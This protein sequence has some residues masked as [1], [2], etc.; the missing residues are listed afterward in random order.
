MDTAQ[1]SWNS[2]TLFAYLSIGLI[3]ATYL[4]KQ[5]PF[6]QKLLIPNAIIAGVIVLILSQKV[7]N[8]INIPAGS[9]NTLVYHLLTGV[10][11]TL[12]LQQRKRENY[13][14]VIITTTVITISNAV[15]GLVGIAFTL[16]GSLVLFQDLHPAFS[17]LP[18]LGFGYDHTIASS[19]GLQ[20]ETVGFI[21]GGQAGYT[22]G[23]MGLL[24]AYL[25]GVILVIFYR[26]RKVANRE[27]SREVLEGIIPRESKK[28]VG[29]YLTTTREG[30]ETLALHLAII[31]LIYLCTFA[32][33]KQL[34][35]WLGLIGTE[36][37]LFG[38][39][40]WHYNF[41]FGALLAYLARLVIDW[42]DLGHLFDSGLMAGISGAMIDYLI[43]A[44]IAAI[45]LVLFA[46]YLPEILIVSLL[47]SAALIAF[48]SFASRRMYPDYPVERIVAT[49]GFMTG[50]LVSGLTL[51]RMADPQ[52]ETPVAKD[53]AYGSGL[54]LLVG[55]PMIIFMTLPLTGYMLGK[56]VPYL[57]ISLALFAGYGGLL[58]LIWFLWN[59]FQRRRGY[60]RKPV[61]HSFE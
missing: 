43:V 28:P 23:V 33:M 9:I 32:L 18:L 55:L 19:V 10:F 21:W 48:I 24:W 2:A 4:R 38:G 59:L 20:W 29:S 54:S 7:I 3:V 14:G 17:M 12:G 56:P 41:V 45:P 58:F 13:S 39:I 36:G 26:K 60:G 52:M 61:Q 35:V 25:G 1:I 46:R 22:L 49:F 31:G 51:L 50:T 40:I 44:S 37:A 16:L 27:S 6:L 53:L 5:I 8:L 42:L 34:S 30:I 11:I 57:L 15:L 47:S